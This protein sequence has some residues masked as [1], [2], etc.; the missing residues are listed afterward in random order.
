MSP[1][2]ITLLAI[3]AGLTAAASFMVG[4]AFSELIGCFFYQFSYLLDCVDGEVARMTNQSSKGGDWLDIGLNYSL[5][6]STFGVLYGVEKNSTAFE[7]SFSVYLIL[8]TIFAEILA[9]NGSS[10]V[11]KDSTV[12]RDTIA[13]RKINKWLDCLVFMFVTQTGFQVGV[14]VLSIC[15]LL[16]GIK[17]A[18][19][20]WVG[21]HL[22]IGFVRACYK[23]KLNMKYLSQR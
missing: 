7:A 6:F 23:L 2:T 1:N 10:L 20:Y 16:L 5:Y 13:T 15:W 17:T 12:T 8:F 22:V 18:L 19:L 4:T 11:F 3:L 9:T 14:L 21:F